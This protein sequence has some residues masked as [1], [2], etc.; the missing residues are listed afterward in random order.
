MDLENMTLD[1]IHAALEEIDAERIAAIAAARDKARPLMAERNRRL[2]A[3]NSAARA[4]AQ[5]RAG[6]AFELLAT[7]EAQSAKPGA[8]AVGA[9]VVR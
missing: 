5:R 8:A 4:N 1:E 7:E 9:K 2:A 3:E 6:R